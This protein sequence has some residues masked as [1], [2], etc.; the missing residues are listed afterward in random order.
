MWDMWVEFVL[1]KPLW[2][3]GG[4]FTLMVYVALLAVV[5][6]LMFTPSDAL[7]PGSKWRVGLVVGAL[8]AFVVACVCVSA[9]EYVVLFQA[10]L[11]NPSTDRR[12]YVKRTYFVKNPLVVGVFSLVIAWQLRH[13]CDRSTRPPS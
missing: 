9:A 8:V 6:V 1:D 12:G 7:R 5:M 4:K 13:L 3:Y 10:W 11:D 2:L